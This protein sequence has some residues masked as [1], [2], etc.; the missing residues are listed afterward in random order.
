MK[1]TAEQI[2]LIKSKPLEVAITLPI[3]WDYAD[4]AI[5]SK[6]MQTYLNSWLESRDS[7]IV[8]VAKSRVAK[9]PAYYYKTLKA[10]EWALDFA[11][12]EN[13]LV[14]GYEPKYSSTKSIILWSIE[15]SADTSIE[16]T[17][18]ATRFKLISYGDR[19]RDGYAFSSGI[20]SV[21]SPEYMHDCVARLQRGDFA[22][23]LYGS[24]QGYG[25]GAYWLE[26]CYNNVEVDNI[27]KLEGCGIA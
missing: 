26:L 22:L 21:R 1:L 20:E 15:Q 6:E 10:Q 12:V 8:E 16:T 7:T 27:F 25:D 11:T 3:T 13:L 17:E 23:S 9:D 14:A 4:R 19:F 24:D 2:Q 18:I 5:E